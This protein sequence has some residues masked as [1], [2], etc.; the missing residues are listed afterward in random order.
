VRRP[1]LPARGVG[2]T[3]AVAPAR[4]RERARFAERS[5]STR[6][7]ASSGPGWRANATI[8]RAVRLCWV[9]LVFSP[10][11]AKTLADDGWSKAQARQF[12]WQRLRKPVRDLVPGRDGGEGVSDEML[13][14]C[15]DGTRSETLL[16][17][18]QTPD[19]LKLL[20]AGGTAGRFTAIV[21]DWPVRDAPSRLV[22]R[23]IG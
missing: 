17:K 3:D 4:H 11:H 18:F 12:L 5:T 15:P 23:K 2:H 8:G 6:A 21:P 22:F 16:P 7:R 9:T 1:I 13:A 10:E 14:T 19:S 20:I